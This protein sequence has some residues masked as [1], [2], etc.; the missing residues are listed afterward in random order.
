MKNPVQFY[1]KNQLF[2]RN[3]PVISFDPFLAVFRC[4]LSQRFTTYRSVKT[5]S[6][7]M[8]SGFQNDTLALVPAWYIGAEHP[9]RFINTR[10]VLHSS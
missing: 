10:L 7:T 1:P 9:P 2:I 4:Q 5:V 8:D 6:E 3:M